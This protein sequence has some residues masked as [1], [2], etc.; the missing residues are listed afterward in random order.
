MREDLSRLMTERNLDAIVVS[1]KVHG[2]P[3]LT[4]LTKGAGLTQA[5]IIQKRGAAPQAIINPMEREEAAVLGYPLTLSSRYKYHDLLR[6]HDGDAL[7]ATVAYYARIFEDLGVQGRVGF[8]GLADQGQA[9]ALL[10]AVE[11]SLPDIHVVAEFQDDLISAARTTKDT[12]EVA[13]IR[14]MGR[15][16]AEIVRQTE[17]FLREHAV[18]DEEQLRRADG[19]ILTVGDVHAHIR[20]L[21]ALQGLEDPEGFI[22]ATGR[23]SGIPHSKGRLETPMRL[24]ESIVFDI[25]PC[26]AGGGYFFDMTRT[27][28]LGY[29]PDKLQ[30]IY[31]DVFACTRHIIANLDVGTPTRRYQQMTCAFFRERGY[32][33]VEEDASVLSGYIHSLGHGVGLELHETPMFRDTPDN[34]AQIA[35]GHVFTV[36]P[37]LYYPDEGMGC[38]IE[39]VIYIDPDGNIQNLTDYPYQLVIPMA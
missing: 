17:A 11:E 34:T 26:E 5:L 9:Y 3:P 39:D 4:Y 6:E 27:F 10:T 24:G 31:D 37:G 14:E 18:D 21:V 30:H 32:A 33:T 1:G 20:R 12:A 29:A 8:Y 2:N 36:E 19:E 38:R 25:F 13:R 23:D 28:C 22:F 7:Q 15:R 35:P 16:T